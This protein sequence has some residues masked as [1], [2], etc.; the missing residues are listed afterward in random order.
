MNLTNMARTLLGKVPG[1]NQAIDGI[2]SR[3]NEVF[4]QQHNNDTGEH[5][6]VT[7]TSLSV[8]PKTTDNSGTVGSALAPSVTGTYDLGVIGTAPTLPFFAWRNLYLTTGIHWIGSALSAAGFHIASWSDVMT[9]GGDRTMTSNVSG[10]TL[11]FLNDVGTNLQRINASVTVGPATGR[12]VSIATLEAT[13]F[14]ADNG[15]FE[16]SRTVAQGVW[17]NF[18]PT[19]TAATGTWTGS[20]ITTAQ[21]MLIGK[22]LF[23]NFEI[24]AGNNSAATASLI[25]A[26]PGGFTAAKATEVRG[27]RA[28]DLSTDVTNVRAHVLAG[29]TTVIFDRDGAANWSINAANG[30]YVRGQ[31]F[32]E[33]Q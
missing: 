21:Y 10:Q 17:T 22:T 27:I 7:A 32:F 15:V 11:T 31:I 19:Q 29:G 30:N 18:T 14:A 28:L 8:P 13:N 9:A 5:T 2:C 16:R 12:G 4:G 20:T 1:A 23:L 26:I 3:A 24:D 33:I 25:F 6:T